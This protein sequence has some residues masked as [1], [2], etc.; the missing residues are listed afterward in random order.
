MSTGKPKII[1][2]EILQ[3]GYEA[4]SERD[5]DISHIIIPFSQIC[6]TYKLI[7]IYSGNETIPF[8]ERDPEYKMI[9]R[10]EFANTLKS[11]L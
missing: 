7:D 4:L 8:N 3:D 6:K 2:Q 10:Q 5:P 9:L 1:F 11:E